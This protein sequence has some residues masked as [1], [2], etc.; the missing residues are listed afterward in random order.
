[1]PAIAFAFRPRLWT[2]LKAYRR[3]DLPADVGAGVTVALVALPLAMAFAIAS[4]V[5][6][7]QGIVTAIVGG[8]LVSLFGGSKVQI[9]GPAGAFVAMLYAIAAKYGVANLLIATMMAGAILFALGAL[10]L[11]TLVRFIPVSIVT[12]FTA[13]IAIII[14]LSQVKD[15]LGLAVGKMPANFFSQLSV[16]A[17]SVTSTNLT[18]LAIGLSCVLVIVLWP[19]RPGEKP[20]NWRWI[21]AKLPSTVVVLVFSA[22]T[23]WALDLKVETLGT[24]FGSLPRGIP[25]PHAPDF[26]W[27]TAQNLLAPAI[28]IA[29]LGA[30][31]SLLCARVADGMIGDRHDPNQELMAQGMANFL[32]PLFGGIAVTGTIARTMTNVRSGARSPVAGLVHS[33]TLLLVMVAFAP[34]AGYIPL[35]A[36]AA[37]LL[38]VAFNMVAWRELR[39]LRKFSV[40]YRSILIAT[41]TLTVVFDLTVA[42]EVGLVLSSLFFIYRISSLTTVRPIAL[43]PRYAA[44][45][46][47]L[48]GIWELFGSIFFGSVTKLEALLDP[49]KPLPDVVVLD[50]GKVINCDT[51]GL[52]ALEALH[53]ALGRRGGRLVLAE[54]NEQPASLLARSG[55][56][57]ILGRE[58][59]FPS[60]EAALDDIFKEPRA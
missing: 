57:A 45:A 44:R 10:R 12:G 38:W 53:G 24:R 1:V 39:D 48:V 42:V 3:E 59:I 29:L 25:M 15:F 16:L 19:A 9:A 56:D 4:G 28:A 46:A 50:M 11:G 17:G 2:S 20:G 58:N 22:F 54:P 52:D 7:E 51:T 49:A 36:L 40:F 6:P 8:V 18:T 41:L 30:I 34:A 33:A 26:D 5:R 14:A 37:V 43:P 21:T 27:A 47:P 31:E 23:V 32:S 60:L 55:F 13:G 35:S